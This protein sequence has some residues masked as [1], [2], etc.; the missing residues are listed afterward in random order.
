[1]R[2]NKIID[3]A[4]RS[5]SSLLKKLDNYKQI[6]DLSRYKIAYAAMIEADVLAELDFQPQAA[7][8]A[9]IFVHILDWAQA[10]I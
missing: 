7:A 4:E 8:S 10:S 2:T 1:M 3:Q 9:N 6:T 5:S